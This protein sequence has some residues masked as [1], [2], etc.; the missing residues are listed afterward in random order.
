[1]T[2]LVTGWFSAQVTADARS[3]YGPLARTLTSL[4]N[5]LRYFCLEHCGAVQSNDLRYLCQENCGAI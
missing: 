5:D 3:A 1:M 2:A 4:G